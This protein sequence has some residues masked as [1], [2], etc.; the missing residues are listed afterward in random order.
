MFKCDDSFLSM[1]VPE[2]A[3][4]LQRFAGHIN[5]QTGMGTCLAVHRCLLNH[6]TSRRS[7][8]I[9][10]FGADIKEATFL[11]DDSLVAVGAHA[12]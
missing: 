10:W 5:V 12:T 11:G 3:R 4:M 2:A 7:C 6:Y 9:L 1:E 8:T